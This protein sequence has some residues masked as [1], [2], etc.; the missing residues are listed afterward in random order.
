MSACFGGGMAS[1]NFL[2]TSL[3]P[4]EWHSLPKNM[5]LSNILDIWC[6]FGA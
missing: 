5:I 1:S 6:A 2:K 3:S 4:K